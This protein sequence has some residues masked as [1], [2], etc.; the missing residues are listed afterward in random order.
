MHICQS[1]KKSGKLRPR[2]SVG[3]LGA[4]LT[5]G[6]TPRLHVC[7]HTKF[8]GSRSNHVGVRRSPEKFMTLSPALLWWGMRQPRPYPKGRG[9][10]VPSNVDPP[11]VLPTCHA[12]F[13]GSLGQTEWEWWVP[14]I[15]GTLGPPSLVFTLRHKTTIL[16]VVTHMERGVF[17]GVS[18]SIAYCTNTSRSLSA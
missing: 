12:E 8:G 16:G 10:R 18:H 17:Y 3:L 5:A 6:N 4:W 9:H 2:P 14:K 7:Y 15:L 1:N 11:H 13:G